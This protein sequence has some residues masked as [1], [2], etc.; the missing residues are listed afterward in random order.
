MYRVEI[1]PGKSADSQSNTSVTKLLLELEL[2]YMLL[3]LN[4]TPEVRHPEQAKDLL[5][6]ALCLCMEILR[7]K[8]R[9]Q[10]DVPWGV[11]F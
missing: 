5:K 9:T 6:K 10:D 1:K 2:N 7:A 4:V 3:D 11:I 8:R